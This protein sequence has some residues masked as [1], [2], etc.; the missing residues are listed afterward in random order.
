[1]FQSESYK[2]N[3]PSLSAGHLHEPKNAVVH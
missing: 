2:T 3:Y 1:M